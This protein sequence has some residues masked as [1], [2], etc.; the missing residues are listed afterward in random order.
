[1]NTLFNAAIHAVVRIIII[2]LIS[3]SG[4]MGVPGL[5]VSA[6]AASRMLSGFDPSAEQLLRPA[7]KH[8]TAQGRIP[9]TAET[10]HP[11]LL[12]TIV[13]DEDE[14]KYLIPTDE[15]KLSVELWLN[16]GPGTYDIRLWHPNGS[17]SYSP[18]AQFIVEN[19][20]NRQFAD[21]E[22][23]PLWYGGGVGTFA[24]DEPRALE[25]VSPAGLLSTGG[26]T[27]HDLLLVSVEKD[28]ETHDQLVPVDED[29]TFAAQVW[30]PFGPGVYEVTFWAPHE[31]RWRA[32]AG[33]H[34]LA[35]VDTSV[36]R[37]LV[38]TM[39]MESDHP[40]ITAL[41]RRIAPR[42]SADAWY[43]AWSVY[44][45]VGKNI[46]YDWDKYVDQSF[47][48]DDGAVKTLH[49]G[50]G[51]CQ[52]YTYL[53]V[54]LLRASGLEA[55]YASGRA[56]PE[57]KPSQW[58]D[59]AWTEVFIDGRWVTMD[60]TWAAGYVTEDGRFLPDFKPEYFDPDPTWF[61]LTHEL[62]SYRR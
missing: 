5:S 58:G 7:A 3:L 38:P 14:R 20:D 34:A 1:M 36:L 8:T 21:V 39:R 59:H 11:D 53:T 49:L 48:S 13:K 37:Y 17:G 57:G 9:I 25:K 60:T 54:A 40:E 6:E 46:R 28:G 51:V 35:T 29:G 26:R 18:W 52:D 22:E 33:F 56:G 45:W 15:G 41:A 43:T 2:S 4:L 62:E 47:A 24:L 16:R 10:V 55:R 30:A 12:L 32:L 50:Q 31:D 42:G 19:A 23:A 44:E 27:S 61:A